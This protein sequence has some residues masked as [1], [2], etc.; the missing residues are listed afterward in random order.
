MGTGYR[1]ND[2]PLIVEL[3]D[4]MKFKWTTWGD[5]GSR[6]RRLPVNLVVCAVLAALTAIGPT[7]PL[8]PVAGLPWESEKSSKTPTPAEEEEVSG[9][10]ATAAV[11]AHQRT[12]R[13]RS[14]LAP[15][16]TAMGH[17]LPARHH[18]G[19]Y[20]PPLCPPSE[21]ERLNGVGGPLRC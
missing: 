1:S 19:S 5:P 12:H 15:L 2:S 16:H 3:L 13:R 14:N 11:G 7:N 17:A 8:R 6:L 18:S 9:V 10:K 4:R 20:A 21:R